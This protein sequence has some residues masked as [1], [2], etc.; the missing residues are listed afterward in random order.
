M[1]NAH[2]FHVEQSMASRIRKNT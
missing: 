1:S 2:E